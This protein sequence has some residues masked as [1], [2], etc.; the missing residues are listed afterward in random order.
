MSPGLFVK[1]GFVEE[2]SNMLILLIVYFFLLH[3]RHLKIDDLKYRVLVHYFAISLLK[4]R[5]EGP[6]SMD[7]K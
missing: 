6:I 4:L 5:M 3:Y 2:R 7:L 1:S